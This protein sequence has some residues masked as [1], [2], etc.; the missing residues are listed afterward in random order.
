[1]RYTEE[2]SVNLCEN[3]H[4]IGLYI[5]GYMIQLLKDENNV[6]VQ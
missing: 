2:E 3:H 5:P 4:C 6:N 1:M